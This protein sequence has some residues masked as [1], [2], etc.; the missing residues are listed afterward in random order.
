[1]KAGALS[2]M[3]NIDPSCARVVA[4]NNSSG[5]DS[6]SLRSF[7]MT[8][9]PT[10][11]MQSGIAPRQIAQKRRNPGA[12]VLGPADLHPNKP[13]SGLLGTPGPVTDPVP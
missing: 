2:Q 11:T 1:M 5:A 6:S 12:L 9:H 10:P 3:Q 8:A 7:G 4:R 13:K